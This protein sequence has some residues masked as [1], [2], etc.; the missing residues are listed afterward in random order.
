MSEKYKVIMPDG[1][2]F[3]RREGSVPRIGEAF[4]TRQRIM[5]RV[6]DVVHL[7]QVGGALTDVDVY[8][9]QPNKIE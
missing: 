8:L 9:G 7:E 1:K 6:L 3:V 2:T 5:H 4:V